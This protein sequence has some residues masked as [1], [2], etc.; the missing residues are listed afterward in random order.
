MIV[1]AIDTGA[2]K[3][4]GAA[5]DEQGKVLYKLRYPNKDGSG[6]SILDTYTLIVQELQKQFPIGAIGIGAGGRLNPVDGQVLYAI[7]IYKDYIGIPIGSLMEERFQLPVAVDND[8]RTAVYGEHWVGVAQHYKRVFGIILGTGVGG[9]FLENGQP[10]YGARHS[11]GE[12]GHMILHPGG[13]PC[14]CGQ[15]GCSEQY[16][17]GSALWRGYNELAG[18]KVLASGYEFFA[19]L[20]EGDA[21]AR[22]ILNAFIHDLCCCTASVLNL[23]SPDAVLFG[24]G[25]MDTAHRWWPCFCEEYERQISP[26]FAG[27]PLLRSRGGNDAALQGAAWIALRKCGALP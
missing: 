18:E 13:R 1:A 16:L 5:V 27:T 7:N 11:M 9:G 24:G 4:A 26:F 10:V 14:G 6:P 25:L 17:S 22:Q 12:V 15:R 19:R 3:I 21:R 2:T 23:L 20:D 8:C